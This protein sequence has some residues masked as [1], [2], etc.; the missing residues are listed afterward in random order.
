MSAPAIQV[1]VKAVMFQLMNSKEHQ[2]VKLCQIDSH[3]S[4][5][6]G[7]IVLMEVIERGGQSLFFTGTGFTLP[8]HGFIPYAVTERADWPRGPYPFSHPQRREDDGAL[9][10]V[11]ADRPSVTISVNK[12]AWGELAMFIRLMWMKHAASYE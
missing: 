7:E 4:V 10:F 2:G 1:D 6:K 12:D 5:P 9:E 8:G 11:F 3:P